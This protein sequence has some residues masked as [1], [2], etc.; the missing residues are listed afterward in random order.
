MSIATTTLQTTFS[1]SEQLVLRGRSL[2]SIFLSPLPPPV[3]R[4]LGTISVTSVVLL[5]SRWLYHNYCEFMALGPGGVPYNV[6]GWLTVLFFK[7]FSRETLSVDMYD[8]DS[9]KHTWLDKEFLQRRN[10]PRPDSGFHVAPA[11]QFDQVA[12]EAF[13]KVSCVPPHKEL[14]LNHMHV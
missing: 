1:F 14:N 4:N 7:P 3:K 13:G 10:G 2:C 6:R 12:P 8:R 9:N 11:R 5:L